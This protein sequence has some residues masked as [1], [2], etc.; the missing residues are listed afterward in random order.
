MSA[1]LVS[2]LWM[3]QYFNHPGLAAVI[4][5][6]FVNVHVMTGAL[7]D[8]NIGQVKKRRGLS[9]SLLA[10]FPSRNLSARKTSACRQATDTLSTTA[11]GSVSVIML[12]WCT[13]GKRR[14]LET[15]LWKIGRA[16]RGGKGWIASEADGC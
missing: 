1:L 2:R 7:D 5:R 13:V 11:T 12:L 3:R 10:T 9:L 15:L 6:M 14:V 16:R 8:I 4:G